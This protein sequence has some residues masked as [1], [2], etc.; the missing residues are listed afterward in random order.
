MLGYMQLH[1]II[2]SVIINVVNKVRK[3]VNEVKKNQ[4][5]HLTNKK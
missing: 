4:E 5:W 3:I 1:A 2:T